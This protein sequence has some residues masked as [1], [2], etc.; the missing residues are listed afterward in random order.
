MARARR[1]STTTIDLPYEIGAFERD[2]RQRNRSKNTITTYRKATTALTAFLTARDVDLSEAT[3]TTDLIREFIISLHARLG[4][5]SVSQRFRS[6]QQ[7]MK[8]VAEENGA[9]D[10][11]TGLTPPSVVLNP[12][13]VLTPDDLNALFA[14][15]RGNDFE[16]RRDLAILSLFAD[17]GIRRS[18]M[19][20]I[21][22]SDL[23]MRE[24]V[25]IVIGKGG[26]TRGVPFG[27]DTASRI[28][29]YLRVRRS[30]PHAEA[31]PLWLGRRKA[32]GLG[33]HGI[34]Q[35]VKRRGREAGLTGLHPHIFRH[36]FAHIWLDNGGNEGDLQRLA[37]WNS[38]QML[39]RYGASAAGARA[40]RAYLA[41]RSPVDRLRG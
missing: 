8:F 37:G 34:E 25:V 29:R 9:D 16:A 39:Q 1:E 20:G 13:E 26:R 24:T 19:A 12:P 35:L 41:G 30:H 3:I 23:D 18:E 31:P 2:L 11:M 4:A 33:V 36:T 21:T 17:T 22:T 28:D 40:R 7:F 6:L 5:A 14:A 32:T 27:N 38:P 10:P 15:C